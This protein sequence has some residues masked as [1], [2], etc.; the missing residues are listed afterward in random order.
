[1]SNTELVEMS[2]DVLELGCQGALVTK[3][4][5]RHTRMARGSAQQVRTEGERVAIEERGE[6]QGQWRLVEEQR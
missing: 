4:G 2:R 3:P 6:T 1:L 5:L